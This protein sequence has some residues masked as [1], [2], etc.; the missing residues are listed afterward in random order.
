MR[1]EQ[2][3]HER[4]KRLADVSKTVEEGSALGFMGSGDIQKQ[5]ENDPAFHRFADM[6]FSILRQGQLS[7]PEIRGAVSYAINRE[8]IAS[9]GDPRTYLC[10]DGEMP[11]VIQYRLWH[12][13]NPPSQPVYSRVGTVQEAADRVAVLMEADEQ[14]DGVIESDFGLEFRTDRG[15]EWKNWSSEVGQTIVEY[16]KEKQTEE[17]EADAKK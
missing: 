2:M 12:V 14:N 1:K 11:V 8:V 13:R 17:A 16:M 4:L 9:M 3:S 7:I 15:A 10:R 5:Y 6:V